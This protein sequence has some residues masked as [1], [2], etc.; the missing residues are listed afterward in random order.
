[1]LQEIE[2]ELPSGADSSAPLIVHC[3]AGIGRTGAIIAINYCIK[4]PRF[5]LYF[6]FLF[7]FIEFLNRCWKRPGLST[8]CT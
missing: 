7:F 1:M 8:F 3:S 4:V 5:L 6:S 2:S